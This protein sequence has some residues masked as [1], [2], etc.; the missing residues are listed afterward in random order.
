MHTAGMNPWKAAAEPVSLAADRRRAKHQG[1]VLLVTIA[2]LGFVMGV[3]AVYAIVNAH[4]LSSQA[5]RL[6][7]WFEAWRGQDAAVQHISM[8][9]CRGSQ[10]SSCVIDGDT[11]RLNGERIRL[12]GIDAPELSRPQCEAERLL[13][14]Q[15]T[16]RLSELLSSGP[17]QVRR[18]GVDVY[19]RTLARLRL[20]SGWA[21][22]MLVHEGL[23]R[24]W[25][26]ARRSWC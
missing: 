8:P 7:D 10:Q 25:D 19:G 13:A 22:R 5:D 23:A 14:R 2:A 26:G 1:M 11:I 6:I 20:E 9:R 3:A 12:L 17:W 15:A 21:G 24:N 4:S 18:D 16:I